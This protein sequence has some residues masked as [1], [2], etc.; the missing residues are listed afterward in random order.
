MKLHPLSRPIMKELGVLKKESPKTS[1]DFTNSTNPFGGPYTGYPTNSHQEL[2]EIYLQ[3][4]SDLEKQRFPSVNWPP[5][6]PDNLLFTVGSMDGLDIVFKAFCEFGQDTV[7]FM[8]PSFKAYP[9]FAKIFNLKAVEYP[10]LRDDLS[11]LDTSFIQQTNPKMLIL[12]TP[13]NPTGTELAPGLIS[14]IGEVFSGIIVVDE[15]Y[16]EY[17]TQPSSV[18]YINQ[19]KN[20][21]VLRTLSKAWGM[22][23]LRC[24]VVIADSLII[25]TLKYVQTPFPLATPA[26]EAIQQTLLNPNE[27]QASWDVIKQ[28]RDHLIAE[29]RTLS[30]VTK[31]YQSHANY[32]FF[33][34]EDSSLV[35]THLNQQGMSVADVSNVMPNAIKVSISHPN[36]NKELIKALRELDVSRQQIRVSSSSI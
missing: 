12:C 26:I 31:V 34:V 28:E 21:I 13:N 2:K 36:H 11:Q 3:A 4:M 27:I 6:T 35:I 22:A 17:G 19:Y 30:F 25:D 29:L 9:H 23:G 20:L 32:V 8:H 10:L 7:G 1:I 15:A 5:L 33:I 14:Q 18:Q 24:G 16:H